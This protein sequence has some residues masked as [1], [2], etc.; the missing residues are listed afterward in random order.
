M[1]SPTFRASHLTRAM[2]PIRDSMKICLPIYQPHSSSGDYILFV[3]FIND[4]DNAAI[5]MDIIRKFAD[6]T[7]GGKVVMTQRD[8]DLFQEALNRLIEWANT[9]GMDFNIKKCK[10]MHFGRNS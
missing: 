6:D 8:A 4:L 10:I 7:K 5:L 2:T 3:V 9:W 1:Y